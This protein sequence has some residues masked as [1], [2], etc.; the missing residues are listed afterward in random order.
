MKTLS[1]KLLC[2]TRMHSALRNRERSMVVQRSRIHVW[3]NGS[4][5]RTAL[6]PAEGEVPCTRE[7]Y[8]ALRC[9]L[10]GSSRVDE[11]GDRGTRTQRVSRFLKHTWGSKSLNTPLVRHQQRGSLSPWLRLLELGDSAWVA[12]AYSLPFGVVSAICNA[13]IN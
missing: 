3:H 5:L 13:I 11:E 10:G 8:R 1:V 12:V 4:A 6:M 7:R 9:T 2:H